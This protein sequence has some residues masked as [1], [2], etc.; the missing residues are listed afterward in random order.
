MDIASMVDL[1]DMIKHL[2]E[3]NERI[4]DWVFTSDR[5]SIVIDLTSGESYRFSVG[6]D[7]IIENTGGENMITKNE[8]LKFIDRVELLQ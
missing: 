2:D 1:I 3:E 6:Q 4:S 7:A 5:K 8:F